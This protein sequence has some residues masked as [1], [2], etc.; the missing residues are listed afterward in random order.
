M[1]F[2][3]CPAWLD[4]EGAVRCGLPAEGDSSLGDWH[5]KSLGCR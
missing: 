2:F 4:K 3:D 1:M 5:L